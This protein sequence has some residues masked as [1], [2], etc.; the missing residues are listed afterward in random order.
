MDGVAGALA[1]WQPPDARGVNPRGKITDGSQSQWKWI[2]CYFR[3]IPMWFTMLEGLRDN[4]Q[5]PPSIAS[6]CSRGYFLLLLKVENG[7]SPDWSRCASFAQQAKKKETAS[8]VVNHCDSFALGKYNSLRQSVQRYLS[9]LGFI[10]QR[11]ISG[12]EWYLKSKILTSRKSLPS[13]ELCPF[14]KWNKPEFIDLAM[15][16]EFFSIF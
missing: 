10:N 15:T 16:D 2:L 5:Q 1:W 9:M 6:S 14:K 4:W 11:L 8:G 3:S 13:W 12:K 7:H